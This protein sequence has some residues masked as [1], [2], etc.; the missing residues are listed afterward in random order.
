[1]SSMLKDPN[2]IKIFILYLLDKIGYPLNYSSI[3]AIMIQDGIVGF[4]DFAECF[5]SLVD[6]GHIRE[7][8]PEKSE[9]DGDEED[10]E[11]QDTLYEVTETGRVIAR[12]LSDSL[13]INVRERSY[14]SAIRHLSLAKK[15]ALV[16][17]TYRKE[18]D[19]YLLTCTIRDR[20]GTSMD[21]TVRADSKYQLDRM[22]HN[23]AERPEIV[24]RGVMALLTGEADYLFDNP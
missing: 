5:F 9:E 10:G 16:D 22:M 18:D 11:E 8:K 21:L 6:A 2:E 1:M 19:H 3:G 14:Q 4:F 13:M 17:Y 15:G 24:F 23:F 12:D 20:E 7:I